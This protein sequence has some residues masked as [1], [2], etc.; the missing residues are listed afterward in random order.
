MIGES[1]CV[2]ATR[3][4]LSDPSSMTDCEV[5]NGPARGLDLIGRKGIN[6]TSIHTTIQL[7]GSH[8]LNEP[9]ARSSSGSSR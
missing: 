5:V 8:S 2:K 6:P 7:A 3:C 1:E 9:Q 4:Y